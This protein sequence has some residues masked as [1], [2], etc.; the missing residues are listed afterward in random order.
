M[1]FTGATT[2]AKARGSAP[3]RDKV[4]VFSREWRVFHSWIASARSSI[5]AGSAIISRFRLMRCVATR[6]SPARCRTFSNSTA[7]PDGPTPLEPT[8]VTERT[9]APWIAP[10]H[11]AIVPPNEKPATS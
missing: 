5:F 2:C 9:R 1:P 7:L 3:L 6:S 8:I 10:T 4:G 11:V